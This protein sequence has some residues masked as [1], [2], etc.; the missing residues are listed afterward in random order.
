MR[1]SLYLQCVIVNETDTAPGKFIRR[2][3]DGTHAAL[4]T[5]VRRSGVV[6]F[7]DRTSSL[8]AHLFTHLS[9]L[10]GFHA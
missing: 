5:T 2:T 10:R 6:Y 4:V 9:L 7:T 8:T 3:K 1:H